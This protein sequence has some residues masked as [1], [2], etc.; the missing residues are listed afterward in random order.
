MS[1]CGSSVT[2]QVSDPAKG[3]YTITAYYL[4]THPHE[5]PWW[6]TAGIVALHTG[7]AE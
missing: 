4:V 7:V 5:L 1:A 6:A 3:T 2:N